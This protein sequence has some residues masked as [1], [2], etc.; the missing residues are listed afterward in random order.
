MASST[1]ENETGTSSLDSES[2]DDP[3]RQS[4]ERDR[5]SP[6]DRIDSQEPDLESIEEELSISLSDG[7]PNV[8][9]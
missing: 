5:A 9:I 7:A 2:C 6:I 8:S 4:D 1:K 3:A